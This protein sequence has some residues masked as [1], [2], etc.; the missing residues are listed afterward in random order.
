MIGTQK[1][2]NKTSLGEFSLNIR[3]NA[4]PE[5]GPDQ[6]SGGVC[7]IRCKCS[8][9]TIRNSESVKSQLR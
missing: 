1:S 5:V 2:G 8:I 7:Y 9:K 4:S 3:T 6:D